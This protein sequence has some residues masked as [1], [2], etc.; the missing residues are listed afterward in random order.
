MQRWAGVVDS[1]SCFERET[2]N[3]MLDRRFLTAVRALP[4]VDKRG[5]R[6]LAE[7][8]VRLDRDLARVPLD[9][10]PSPEK[11]TRR[12][13]AR[14]WMATASTTTKAA[15]KLDQRV[16]GHRRPPAGAVVLA[17]KVVEH[18]RAHPE[19][20]AVLSTS[21]FINR[22]WLA[23]MLVGLDEVPASTVAFLVNLATA[24]EGAQGW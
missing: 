18:W 21:D 9:G 5:S 17:A 20:L 8:Q 10:R 15:R 2:V 24:V 12:G 13:P 1:A 16:R 23:A 7:L 14:M 4:P 11:F 19:L 6:F 3:P 22:E